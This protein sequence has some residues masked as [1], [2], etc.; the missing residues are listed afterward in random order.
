MSTIAQAYVQI[1][2]STKGI[3]GS[4]S[5]ALS[6]ES[7]SAGKSSGESI[8]SN[9]VSTLKG[10]IAAAGIGTLIKE[11]LDAGGA[12]QQSFGGL[13]TLYGDASTA[14]KEMSYEAAAAGISA[15]TY[16]EQ[17]VS[18]GAALKQSFGGDV[19]A[20]AEA[21]NQAIL[22]MADNSAK[23]GTDIQ[24]V[25]N[26]YQGFAKGNYTML[27]NL[28]LGYGGTK[29]EMQRLLTEA[30][31]VTGIKYD[32]S[33]FGD[34]TSA[35]HVIQNE[36]GVA[37]VAAEEAK[38]T[39]T[40]SFSSMAAAAQNLMADL[41]LGADITADIQA[42]AT[43]VSNFL[44]G[45]FIPMLWN[46]LSGIPTLVVTMVQTIGA[47]LTEN[48]PM[49]LQKGI[50]M[51]AS[52]VTGIQDNLP[53]MLETAQTMLAEFIGIVE[54][55]LPDILDKGIEMA[56]NIAS[57][58]S[59]NL[60]AV[61]KS[62]GEMVTRF[63]A[64]ILEHLPDIWQKGIEMVGKVAE[65][66][67]SNMPAVVSAIAETLANFLSTIAEKLPDILQK[68]IEMIGE[69]VA[70][71]IQSI[72][73]VISGIGEIIE[74]IKTTFGEVDWK[75]LGTDIIDGIVKG[76]KNAASHVWNAIKDLCSD[77]L[78]AA[79]DFFDI[80]SPSKV[81]ADRVGRWIPA[82]IAEGIEDN[83]DPLVS[84]MDEIGVSTGIGTMGRL[85]RQ[86][87]YSYGA[88]VETGNGGMN[89]VVALLERYLPNIGSDIYMDDQKVGQVIN[90]RLG[91]ML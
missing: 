56:G 79:E 38:T 45:N 9:L 74:N 23:M 87:A 31:K 32:I 53:A 85:A 25:Q 70:G 20:A 40:G 73:D 21:A 58:I 24:S 33:N 46:I 54:E 14:M 84:A 30:E 72:P 12:L 80:G 67:M 91:S 1:I 51:V 75:K 5:S 42:L 2:P 68:G 17:A 7:A 22:D 60:P 64:Y 76:I 71:I 26:A 36:L 63:M 82:G 52:L 16:A 10:V 47:Y 90:R 88:G 78:E 18:F 35:I 62:V 83:M 6:G 8:G 86:S 28:K 81:M 48:G 11:T 89:Q 29:E 66:I 57:G 34:I 59:E 27:D 37:G 55:N 77:A 39:F 19:T 50:E 41:S 49:L 3:S 4:I 61:I 13:D 65:G 43:N 44:V 69:L 15:N